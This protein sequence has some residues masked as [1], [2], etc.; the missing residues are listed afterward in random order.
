MIAFGTLV[1]LAISCR[2]KPEFHRR[3]L[4]IATC[5]L[6][7]APFGRFDYIFNNA[8][9]F[10]CLDLVILLGVARDLLVNRS[11]HAVYRYALPTLIVGQ[12]FTI[13]LWR[14]SPAWWLGFTRS[15]LGLG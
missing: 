12:A 1:F 9:F 8:L 13:Y 5:C 7:D 15:L 14:G 6:M 2:A 10:P 4:F 3:L 11:I